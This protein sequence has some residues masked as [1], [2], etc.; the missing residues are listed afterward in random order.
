MSDFLKNHK[1]SIL[2]LLAGIAFYWSF[3]YDLDRSDFI[4]L[5]SLYTGLFFISFKIIQLEKT[6]FWFLAGIA[7]LFRLIFIIATPNLSQDFYRFIWDGTLIL[8]GLNP[9]LSV[10]KELPTS[11]QPISQELIQGMGSLSAGNYTSYP[12]VNQLLFAISALL[13]GKSILGSLVVMRLLIILAD[14]GILYFGRKLLLKLDLPVHQIFWFILNPF[15]IIELTGNLHFEGVMLFFLVWSVYLLHQKKWI[16][17]AVLLGISVSVKLL[18]LLFLPLLWKYFLKKRSFKNLPDNAL[19]KNKIKQVQEL[20]FQQLFTYYLIAGFT[21]LISFLPFI[22]SEFIT[23]FSASIVLW[24]QKFEFNASIYYVIRW[25]GFQLKGYN[26]IET[27]GK[28]LPLIVMI[29]LAALAFFRKNNTTER[30]LSTMLLGVSAY[31]LL[32][33]TVHPWY[34]ATPLLLSV[35]TNFRFALIWSFLV[36]LSY[37]AYSNAEFKENFWLIAIEYILV[38]GIFLLEIFRPRLLS[39]FPYYK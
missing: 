33:T 26:I 38:I 30:L 2:L 16:R 27:A 36:I 17:S 31:F 39:R 18:P 11:L 37:S 3:A 35:F 34:V 25:I 14:L 10:P 9:Y 8:E 7:I 6:N 28:I 32:A 4:K 19:I 12:P 13:G 24:F 23:N 20:N 21:I 29:I 15:I 5:I 22:S 1:F